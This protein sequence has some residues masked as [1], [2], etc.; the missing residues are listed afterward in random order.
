MRI[1]N[2]VFPGK[3]VGFPEMS[4]QFPG[5]FSFNFISLDFVSCNYCIFKMINVEVTNFIVIGEDRKNI[6][7]TVRL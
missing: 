6:F 1:V 7:K 4:G 5:G 3:F 2:F